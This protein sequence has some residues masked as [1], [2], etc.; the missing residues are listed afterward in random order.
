[1]LVDGRF[2]ELD[3]GKLHVW[4]DPHPH[5]NYVIGGDFAQGVEK[6]N[7]VLAVLDRGTGCIVAEYVD[8]SIDAYEAV[9]IAMELVE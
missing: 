6:S 9:P 2:E 1:M 3:R 4:E 8:P 7:T 5:T